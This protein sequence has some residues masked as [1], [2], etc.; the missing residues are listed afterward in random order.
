[1]DDKFPPDAVLLESAVHR[2]E[3]LPEPFEGVTV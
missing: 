1:M 2:Y 3:K